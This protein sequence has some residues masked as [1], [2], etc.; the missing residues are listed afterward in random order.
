[1]WL[2]PFLLIDLTLGC[3]GQ[4]RVEQDNP[5]A[6]SESE[7][8]DDADA[9]TVLL[10]EGEPEAL[11]EIKEEVSLP[12]N[13]EG[14]NMLKDL[15]SWEMRLPLPSSKA[16]TL[17]LHKQTEVFND[18][19]HKPAF[20]INP[21]VEERKIRP[22]PKLQSPNQDEE[23]AKLNENNEQHEELEAKVVPQHPNEAELEMSLKEDQEVRLE[24]SREFFDESSANED[25]I[26]EMKPKR[27]KEIK[28]GDSL[29]LY[30]QE[31][32]VSEDLQ[33]WVMRLPLPSSNEPTM[34]TEKSK[35]FF[36]EAEGNNFPYDGNLIEEEN[37]NL[38]EALLALKDEELD[39]TSKNDNEQNEA[40]QV[41]L[42]K[43][44]AIVRS[45]DSHE[46]EVAEETD[47]TSVQKK[48]LL[49]D[50]EYTNWTPMN[51]VAEENPESNEDE[52]L[53]EDL[54]E[55]GL[56]LDEAHQFY[57]ISQ[58]PLPGIDA[59]LVPEYLSRLESGEDQVATSEHSPTILRDVEDSV[60]TDEAES[61]NLNQF[62]ETV[63]LPP[64]G[65]MGTTTE[66]EQLSEMES[67]LPS[68]NTPD[69]SRENV[70]ELRADAEVTSV[71]SVEVSPEIHEE[72]QE[73]T[74]RLLDHKEIS[75]N[76]GGAETNEAVLHVQLKNKPEES[77]SA[78]E[79]TFAVTT[80][81]VTINKETESVEDVDPSLPSSSLAR[82]KEKVDKEDLVSQES[83][84][85]QHVSSSVSESWEQKSLSESSAKDQHETLAKE[86]SRLFLKDTQKPTP[87]ENRFDL[88]KSPETILPMSDLK[89]AK[90]RTTRKKSELENH[91]NFQSADILDE[92][93]VRLPSENPSH[94]KTDS[95][96]FVKEQRRAEDNAD[97]QA[98]ISNDA[99]PDACWQGR[100]QLARHQYEEALIAFSRSIRTYAKK[101]LGID[102]FLKLQDCYRQRAYTYLQLNSPAQALTDIEQ[103]LE[104][105]QS[106]DVDR[107]RD[108][109][110]RGRVYA[111]MNASQPAI[112][113]I[114]EALRLG[115]GV[116]DQAYAFYLRG[117]SYL[118][119]TRLKPGLKDLSLGC[120]ADFSEACEL[121][122]QIL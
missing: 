76:L 35:E 77:L 56:K 57:E 71:L 85:N 90:S 97:D 12:A 28:K 51:S 112:D 98:A 62:L 39:P 116:K 82:M 109:F 27:P 15:Q 19:E 75:K 113:D 42:S 107:P 20:R 99:S 101:S 8:F 7:S 55:E 6:T 93:A 80:K 63:P 89:S 79:S 13:G 1:M 17:S 18:S 68:A 64:Y 103:V 60:S 50:T 31:A 105:S 54:T 81:E 44:K 118:R 46:P 66:E 59:L 47:V 67:P 45:E 114:S 120:Q 119:L 36:N 53:A 49:H 9:A 16:P 40:S 95:L 108:L 65:E 91:E 92:A 48:S 106:E 86:D 61:E 4:T 104:S 73:E 74:P 102:E 25:S 69:A 84:L 22:S 41:S 72:I 52:L 111:S 38:K 37:G 70:P 88:Q 14:E 117:L 110:F 5:V 32:K 94:G 43:S 24:K 29:S 23:E 121:L 122:D 33:S 2:L 100:V 58:V 115:L 83:A 30:G 10:D 78:D 26:V 34:S 96:P 87:S 11:N 3:V 21:D